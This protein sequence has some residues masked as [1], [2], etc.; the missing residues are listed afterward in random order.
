MK[1]DE[2]D[3]KILQLLKED[4]RMSYAALGKKI[5]LTSTAI[6]QRVQ[7]MTEEGIILGFGVQ[8]NKEKLGFQIQALLSLKL[9]FSRIEAFNKILQE[10]EEIEY[11]FRVTGEDCIVMKVNLRDNQHLR[12]FINRVSVYGFTKTNIIFEQLI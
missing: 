12:N 10:F 6:G 4:G 7:K 1:I 8:V 11:C 2:T 5:G 3:K 9:N